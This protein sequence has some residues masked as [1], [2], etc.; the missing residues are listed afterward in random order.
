MINNYGQPGPKIKT[1][2]LLIVALSLLFTQLSIG[3]SN[4]YQNHS[5][6]DSLNVIEKVYLHVDRDSY[7]AGDDIWFK[8]YLIDAKDRLLTD[9]SSNLHVELISPFSKIISNRIIRIDGGLGNGDFKLP[10]DI[11]S[12]RYTLRAYTNYMRNFGDQLFFSKEIVVINS[13]D[14]TEISERVKYVENKIKISFFPEGGSL[15]DNVSSIVAFKVENNLGKGC[16]VSGK[17]FSS[18]GDLITT[19][20]STH[21]GMGS[22]FLR[23]LPGL[24]Y[25][26]IVRGADSIDIKTELPA[27]FKTGVTMLSQA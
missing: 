14:S 5:S 3:R 18:K 8:A 26:S 24:S 2:R 12:G 13:T 6:D 9:H 1:I 21:L 10:V 27:S 19:F 22:F 16:D 20:R 11:R 15:V 23:P 17:I 25:Y 4:H 7:F